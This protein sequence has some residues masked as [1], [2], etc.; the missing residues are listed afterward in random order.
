MND[1]NEK[2]VMVLMRRGQIK[3][4]ECFFNKML[5]D[6]KDRKFIGRQVSDIY[7]EQK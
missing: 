3:L 4:L 7:R 6:V 5:K 1:S 2:R